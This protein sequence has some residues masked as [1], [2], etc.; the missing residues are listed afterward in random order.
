VAVA[1]R[2]RPAGTPATDS[3]INR[4]GWT[5]GGSMEDL[6]AWMT[7]ER[8]S[9]PDYQV[10]NGWSVGD[11]GN[12]T[13]DQPGFLLRH[14]WLFPVMG[15]G[16]G[17][18]LAAAGV[19][20]GAA[21]SAAADS[22]AVGG[23]FAPGEVSIASSAGGPMTTPGVVAA[24]Q[25]GG[26]G[27]MA[28]VGRILGGGSDNPWVQGANIVLRGIGAVLGLRKQKQDRE[29]RRAALAIQESTLDPYRGQM[30]QASDTAQL[31]ALANDNYTPPP[32]GFTGAASRY[33]AG[34]DLTP[35]A[36]YTPSPLARDTARQGMTS[37]A[38]GQGAG[39]FLNKDNVGQPLPSVRGTG[40]N[41]PQMPPPPDPTQTLSPDQ[42][43]IVRRILARRAAP[44]SS[45][46]DWLNGA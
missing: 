1:R 5:P 11:D 14:P 6:D 26:R 25:T 10:P 2:T 34:M 30:F 4:P 40:A 23:D 45:S 31:D 37:V 7:Q 9:N 27:V 32:L 35:R 20:A 13:R 38:S 33:T 44:P 8:Q 22:A 28:N 18:G 24:S 16:A 43:N 29:D 17:A 15:I 21:T 12:V 42:L 39:S 3:V 41:T 46:Y 19:G 36:A